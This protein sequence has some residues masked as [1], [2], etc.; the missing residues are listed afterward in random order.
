MGTGGWGWLQIERCCHCS[1]PLKLI[2]LNVFLVQVN[3][4]LFSDQL[5][6]IVTC[7]MIK[8]NFGIHDFQFNPIMATWYGQSVAFELSVISVCEA[9]I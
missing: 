3:A 7:S 4:D 9:L 2:K 8:T 1:M 6:G 5:R